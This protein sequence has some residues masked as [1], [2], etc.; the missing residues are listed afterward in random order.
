M[1]ETANI[2]IPG[3]ASRTVLVIGLGVAMGASILSY[4]SAF[5]PSREHQVMTICTD[6]RIVDARPVSGVTTQAM[7]RMLAGE[8]KE[9]TRTASS[10]FM[11]IV[12]NRSYQRIISL[13]YDAVPLIMAEL[14]S[15]PDH[16]GWALQAITGVNPVPE[17]ADGDIDA[18][19]NAW[20][21]WGRN[22]LLIG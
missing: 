6:V 13:G 4:G 8:W 9:Q 19:A 20:L 3:D 15:E 7:F 14:V 18:I 10:D 17:E 2:P 1:L 5:E 12:M 21:N 16:W 22:N 11:A